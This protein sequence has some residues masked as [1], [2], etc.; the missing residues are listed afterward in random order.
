MTCPILA[1][2]YFGALILTI[3]L[4]EDQHIWE[5]YVFA[6]I[7]H[8]FIFGFTITFV[9]PFVTEKLTDVSDKTPEIYVEDEEIICLSLKEQKSVQI[10]ERLLTDSSSKSE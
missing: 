1:T 10:S 5:K 9:V 3:T 6:N 7:I 2:W 4:G 8:S